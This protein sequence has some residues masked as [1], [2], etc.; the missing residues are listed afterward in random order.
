MRVV[1]R[2]VAFACQSLLVRDPSLAVDTTRELFFF[3]RTCSGVS[4]RNNMKISARHHR[5]TLVM[6]A[7]HAVFAT[8]SSHV[9]PVSL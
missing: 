3:P 7:A 5:S 4:F 1:D 9:C 2:F 6:R 8:R